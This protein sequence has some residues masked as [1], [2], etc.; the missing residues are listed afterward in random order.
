MPD[1]EPERILVIC[2][3]P[4][5]MDFG[6]AGSIA[7]WTTAGITVT[8]CLVTSGQAGSE[9]RSLTPDQVAEVRI[10]EQ[11]A[12]AA[13][14]GVTNL[15]WLGW[16]DGAVEPTLVLRREL[17]RIIRSVR[18]D[19]VVTQSP[20]LNLDRIY[21]SHPDHLATGQAALAAVYPDARNPHAHPELL[22]DG[23][24]PWVVP[25]VWLMAG[26]T[27]PESSR[28]HVDITTTMDNKIAALRCH[29]S[30]NQTWAELDDVIR[31]W[32]TLTAVEVG[33]PEGRMAEAFRRVDTP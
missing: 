9:D 31:A 28:V 13:L 2:A 3:H 19:R 26:P 1:T 10:A 15:I 8:Y 16:P 18:P 32:G 23:F 30:Q 6:A 4:D 11:T 12:A 17:S 20:Q 21:A 27:T 25:E 14:V 24:E 29:R 22:A 33:L 5:D 7:H